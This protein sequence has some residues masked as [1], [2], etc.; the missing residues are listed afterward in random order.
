MDCFLR[1]NGLGQ[2]SCLCFNA[3]LLPENAATAI[4]L[5]DLNLFT[6]PSPHHNRRQGHLHCFLW[7]S[8]VPRCPPLETFPPVPVGSL[9]WCRHPR[10]SDSTGAHPLHPLERG[11]PPFF[12][13]FEGQTIWAE[14]VLRRW[15]SMPTS[16]SLASNGI[17]GKW[18]RT[19]ISTEKR[20]Q[21]LKGLCHWTEIS[22]C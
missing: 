9:D 2:C 18:K 10:V 4:T 6:P 21:D 22:D 11:I 20:C 8:C 13:T 3:I 15:W 14:K 5:H 1:Q 7:W 19:T 12:S 17:L 16:K